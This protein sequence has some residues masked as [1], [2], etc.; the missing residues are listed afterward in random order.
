MISLV[1]TQY[2]VIGCKIPTASFLH[3][4]R[5]WEDTWL[6]AGDEILLLKANNICITGFLNGV[7]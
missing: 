5:P 2:R 6:L 1:S 4:V 7:M 3:T